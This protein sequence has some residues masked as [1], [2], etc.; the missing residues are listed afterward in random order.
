MGAAMRLRCAEAASSAGDGSGS[1]FAVLQQLHVRILTSFNFLGVSIALH[2][3][4]SDAV[5][6]M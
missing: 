5:A 6:R 2:E 1:C 4:K 3:R